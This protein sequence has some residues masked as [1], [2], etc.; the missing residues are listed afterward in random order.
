MEVCGK[1][2]HWGNSHQYS[3][4]RGSWVNPRPGLYAAA[5]SEISLPRHC[6]PEP[7]WSRWQTEKFPFCAPVNQ[8]QPGRGSKQKNFPSLPLWTRATLDAVANRTIFLLR[9]CE[10]EPVWTRQQTEKFPFCAPVNQG[11]SRRGGKQNN[12][13]SAPQRTITRCNLVMTNYIRQMSGFGESTVNIHEA[14]VM[15]LRIT[16]KT[17]ALFLTM[18]R[19]TPTKSDTVRPCHIYIFCDQNSTHHT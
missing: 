17:T 11:Q 8:G 1:L 19:Q 3:L 16:R 14:T 13:S 7:V 9:P 10:P 12:F 18:S 6:E 4:Y 5:K 15:K 2:Y